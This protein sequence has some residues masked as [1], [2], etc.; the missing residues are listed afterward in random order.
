MGILPQAVCVSNRPIL[1]GID[2]T[3]S[4]AGSSGRAG[5]AKSMLNFHFIQNL[6]GYQITFKQTIFF[7]WLSSTAHNIS[8]LTA[9]N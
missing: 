9:L 3:L 1:A 5:K 7:R 8:H 2:S 6:G 4:C